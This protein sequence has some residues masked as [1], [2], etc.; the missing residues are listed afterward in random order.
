MRRM[1]AVLLCA[2]APQVLAQWEVVKESLPD[3]DGPEGVRRIR[4]LDPDVPV[5]VLT[6]C[7]DE[8]VFAE[9]ARS[10][11]RDYLLKGDLSQADLRRAIGSA[12]SRTPQPQPR[13]PPRR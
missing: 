13:C 9:C 12:L 2:V 10:G 3:S 7:E 8:A 6:G 1:L 5:V 4:E 11:A